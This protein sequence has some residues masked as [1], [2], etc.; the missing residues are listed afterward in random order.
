MKKHLIQLLCL[1]LV[2][3]PK[4][5]VIK[6]SESGIRIEDILTASILLLMMT[7]LKNI[8]KNEKIKKITSIFGVYI[9]FCII[10]MLIGW[11]FGYVNLITSMLFVIRKIEYFVFIYFGYQYYK[12][13]KNNNFKLD[14][15]VNIITFFHLGV[16]LLQLFGIIGSFN[17]GGYSPNLH[18]GRI[19]SIFN[20]SY[21]FSAFMLIITAYYISDICFNKL[22]NIN[23]V[24]IFGL[25]TASIL[26]FL[27]N[28][29]ISVVILLLEYLL[30]IIKKLHIKPSKKT[31]LIIG[32]SLCGIIGCIALLFNFGMFKNSRFAQ[33]SLNGYIE[34]IKCAMENRDFDN[35]L[36]TGSWFTSE[37]CYDVG[38]DA[39]FNLRF[40][41][42]AQLL[43]GFFRHPLFGLG[44]SI[45]TEAADGNYIR[46]LVE[47]G[48]VGI[49]LWILLLIQIFKS[50]TKNNQLNYFAKLSFYSVLIGAIFI[51][52]FEASRIMPLFWLIIGWVVSYNEKNKK[53]D[54]SK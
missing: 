22:K 3:F 17:A 43:D 5:D 44:P 24:N 32:G 27:S 7:D 14:K 50:L 21:E 20:G 49:V 23:K 46:I 10:S 6:I 47:S 15:I 16:C 48:V 54:N 8:L 45:T 34:S 31:I 13:H 9:L 29:R 42:W 53:C 41:H 33:I 40:N 26:I 25:V 12:Y 4:I 36:N 30:G 2:F 28:S 19:T 51:D 39:S 11:K 52:L 35:Y 37:V 1:T 18:Q 38:T